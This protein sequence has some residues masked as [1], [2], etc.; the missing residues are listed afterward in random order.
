MNKHHNPPPSPVPQF[1]A[2]VVVREI[3]TLKLNPQN[4][5]THSPA[6]IRKIARSIRDLGF[7]N[8]ILVDGEGM[9]LAGHGRLAAAKHLGL[10][11]VPTI[12]LGHLSPA[13]RRAYALIDNKSAELAGWDPNLL[14]LEFE[15]LIELDPVFDLSVT[16]FEDGELDL[17]LLGPADQKPT[18]APE[19]LVRQENAV[20]RLGDIWVLGHHRVI[21]GDARDQVTYDGLLNGARVAMAFTDPPYNVAIEGHVTTRKTGVHRPFAMA[22]GELDP[23]AFEAFLEAGLNRM[24][25]N[26]RPG[27]VHMVY[28]DWRHIAELITVGKRV[29]G[30]LL[31]VCVWDKGSGGMGSLYRSQHELVAVFRTGG[32]RHRNNVQLGRHGRNRTNVWR[33]PGVANIASDL[34]STVDDHP[35]IKPVALVADA[36]LDVTR[37]DDLVLDPFGG[38]GTTLLAAEQTSRVARLIELDPAYVDLTIRRWERQTGGVARLLQGDLT[39]EQVAASDRV[40]P[41]PKL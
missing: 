21:C 32:G 25:S 27:S 4:P 36:I 34:R 1:A 16:G 6:Q 10:E 26:S 19:E 13:E 39:F 9:I 12:E 20:S 5:R 8:P 11:N 30:D 41:P 29:Y 38:S 15:T 28:M 31:N 40:A 33:Y 24:A 7:N 18:A 35:T 22:V 17:I 3:E 37:A 23:S 2:K 14:K